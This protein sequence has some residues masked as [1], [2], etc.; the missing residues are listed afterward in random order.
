VLL[1]RDGD[2]WTFDGSW[3]QVTSSCSDG[4]GLE[5]EVWAPDD[6]LAYH[7]LIL[8]GGDRLTSWVAHDAPD[9]FAAGASDAQWVVGDLDELWDGGP[10][11]FGGVTAD[12]EL[13]VTVTV[14]SNV[15]ITLE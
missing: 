10:I 5:G 3:V 13:G 12:E 8:T 15:T 11:R 14:T 2:R 9:D 7:S 4:V 6:G 1:E